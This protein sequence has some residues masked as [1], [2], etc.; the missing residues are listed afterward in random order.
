MSKQASSAPPPHLRPP[1]SYH[2]Y[3]LLQR[4]NRTA[5]HR[6]R[7]TAPPRSLAATGALAR[8]NGRPALVAA[9]VGAQRLRSALRSALRS[10][11][12]YTQSRH[13]SRHV[14]LSTILGL[15]LGGSTAQ[16]RVFDEPR[17]APRSGLGSLAL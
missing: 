17:R 13:P 12:G 10:D 6:P 8:P 4:I 5:C 3:R 14:A 1:S 9:Q 2:P 7:A 11:L 16:K 15:W